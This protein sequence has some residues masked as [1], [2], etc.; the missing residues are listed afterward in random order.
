MATKWGGD[1]RR[2][3]TQ[4]KEFLVDEA[5][6]RVRGVRTTLVE[7]NKDPATGRWQLKEVPDSEKVYPCQLVL[8][9]M[10]FIGPEQYV[11]KNMAVDTDGRSNV[12]TPTGKYATS[13]DKVFAAGDCRRGQSL[14]V[15]AITEG[16]H[17]CGSM[18]GSGNH[19]P[20]GT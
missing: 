11:I 1:P 8:L 13:I 2:F 18:H 3:N 16:R 17:A 19:T 4:S 6:G 10:G 7:W 14:V 12:K 15:W 5:T 20:G 9:A